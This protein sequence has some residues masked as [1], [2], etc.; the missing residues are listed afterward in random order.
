MLT[1]D[2]AAEHSD[3]QDSD[4]V[5]RNIMIT[6]TLLC[7]HIAWHPPMGRLIQQVKRTGLQAQFLR[8]AQSRIQP[9]G[10]T[11]P[12]RPTPGPAFGQFLRLTR[13]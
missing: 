6:S 10:T 3:G 8:L 4:N 1:H 12:S 11:S 9:A 2:V 5:W 7:V 13:R